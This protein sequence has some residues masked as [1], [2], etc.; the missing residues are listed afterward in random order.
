[1][2]LLLTNSRA[3]MNKFLYGVLDLV[4]TECRNTILLRD[5]TISKLVTNAQQV[6]G[7]RISEKAN[8]NKQARRTMTILSK[9]RVVEIAC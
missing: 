5:L 1:M 8:D 3:Q 4:K 6:E 7:D 9:N 2:G